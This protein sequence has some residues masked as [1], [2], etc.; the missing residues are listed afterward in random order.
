MCL[1]D[2]SIDEKKEFESMRDLRRQ[3]LKG[4]P[5]GARAK[6]KKKKKAKRKGEELVGN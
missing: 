5:S 4:I 1:V 6:K 2:Q 3:F